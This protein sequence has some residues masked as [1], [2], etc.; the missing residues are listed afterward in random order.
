M[1]EYT[2]KKNQYEDIIGCS[3]CHS[4]VETAKFFRS[5]LC[6][7]CANTYITL[8]SNPNFEIKQVMSQMFNILEKRLK[9]SEP[10]KVE[11]VSDN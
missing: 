5:E 7:Y 2:L 4:P 10:V 11:V 3:C 8:S 9:N 1:K 6:E